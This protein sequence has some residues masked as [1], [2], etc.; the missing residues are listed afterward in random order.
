MISVVRILLTLTV[1]Q[2]LQGCNTAPQ[3]RQ[4]QALHP[5]I[6]VVNS[7]RSV[8]RYHI[9]ETAFSEELASEQIMSVNLEGDE[10]PTETL[11]D[12]LN[13]QKFAAIYCIGAK[14]L[15]SIDYLAPAVPVIYSSVLSWRQFQHKPDYYGVTSEVAPSAQLA[16]FK[17]FFPETKNIGVLYST[18]NSALI[19]EASQHANALSITLVAEKVLHQTPSKDQITNLLNRVDALWILPDPVVLNTERDTV[20]LFEIAHQQRKAVFSYNSFFMTLGATLSINAD[21][22]TT[23]RQAA[24]IVQSV[25]ERGTARKAIQFPAGSSISLN[26]KKVSDNGLSLNA[27]ALNSVSELLEQ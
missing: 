21:L 16:W 23:G 13:H 25:K 26:L 10:Q 27:E 22:A 2:L 19:E 15:G 12:I 1:L 4:D 17:H 24:L 7:N 6:L 3:P 5:L 20:H 11:Q 8:P 18:D 14:A 9:A